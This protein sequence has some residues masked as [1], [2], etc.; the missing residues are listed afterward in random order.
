VV[1]QKKAISSRPRGVAR[2]PPFGNRPDAGL[3]YCQ[4]AARCETFSPAKICSLKLIDAAVWH[5]LSP[6]ST[7]AV[8][9]FTEFDTIN[10][11]VPFLLLFAAMRKGVEFYG[12]EATIV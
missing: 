5:F 2:E 3:N 8:A 1:S 6:E 10:L 12:V 7:P 11:T 4:L 9:A